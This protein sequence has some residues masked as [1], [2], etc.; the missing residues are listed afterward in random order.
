[1]PLASVMSIICLQ[2]EQPTGAAGGL[3]FKE[4]NSIW[5][6]AVVFH[7]SLRLISS[8]ITYQSSV[9]TEANSVSEAATYWSVR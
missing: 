5:F 7:S 4:A 1:M 2:R 8:R 3:F 9:A 6:V